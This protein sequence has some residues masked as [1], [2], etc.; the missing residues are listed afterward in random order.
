MFRT[1]RSQV[2]INAERGLIFVMNLSSNIKIDGKFGSLD[3]VVRLDETG[4]SILVPEE[5]EKLK[6]L[7]TLPLN[8]A[9]IDQRSF[10]D[11]VKNIHVE[12]MAG[13][14]GLRFK[15]T[16]GHRV[17]GAMTV[18]PSFTFDIPYQ[19]NPRTE[20]TFLSHG[21]KPISSE[22]RALQNFLSASDR[23]TDITDFYFRKG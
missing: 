6:V 22:L 20:C 19:E 14:K 8:G 13:S 5:G 23:T 4:L 18:K 9:Q 1:D 15:L 16:G 21:W 12:E 10:L 17:V 11:M 2:R 3:I 7:A